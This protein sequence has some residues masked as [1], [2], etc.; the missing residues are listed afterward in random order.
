MRLTK[1]KRLEFHIMGLD[2]SFKANHYQIFNVV[3]TDINSLR[4][5]SEDQNLLSRLDKGK[6]LYGLIPMGFHKLLVK[7][8]DRLKDE[9]LILILEKPLLADFPWE[10]V[11]VAGSKADAESVQHIAE[12]WQALPMVRSIPVSS[13]GKRSVNDHELARR[14]FFPYGIRPKPKNFLEVTAEIQLNSQQP[15]D[16]KDMILGLISRYDFLHIACHAH[17]GH[18]SMTDNPQSGFL[19]SEEINRQTEEFKGTFFMPRVV[20]A[21]CC[22]IAEV[23]AETEDWDKTMPGRFIREDGV[24]VFC[25]NLGKAQYIGD[26]ATSRT[27][28]SEYFVKY[29]R[30]Y[31][32]TENPLGKNRPFTEIVFKTR[33]NQSAFNDQNN[34]QVIYVA[35]NWNLEKCYRDQ[36]LTKRLLAEKIKYPYRLPLPVILLGLLSLELLAA[37]LIPPLRTGLNFGHHTANILLG[38]GGLA[39]ALIMWLVFHLKYARSQ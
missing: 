28:F 35:N 8:K 25:G 13:P 10:Y 7:S 15:Q 39:F 5:W 34:S 30:E 1:D 33:E 24:A 18:F 4:D 31:G 26:A 36:L 21:D 23:G 17:V 19:S 29:F 20:V 37:Q 27:L 32:Y 11:P 3:D 16:A 22:R 12:T 2:S 38:T 6:C 14:A 9:A